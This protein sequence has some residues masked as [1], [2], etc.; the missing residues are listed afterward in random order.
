MK[1]VT[2][3]TKAGIPV[4]DDRPKTAKTEQIYH[5]FGSRSNIPSIKRRWLIPGAGRRS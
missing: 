1:E 4:K 5:I 3:K 2:A